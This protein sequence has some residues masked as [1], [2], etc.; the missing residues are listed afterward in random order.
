MMEDGKTV[1]DTVV[2]AQYARRITE[3]YFL[4][5]PDLWGLLILPSYD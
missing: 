2:L 4:F 5:I 3:S 1:G